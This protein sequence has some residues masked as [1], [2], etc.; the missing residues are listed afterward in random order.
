MGGRERERETGGR[1]RR[2]DEEQT[3]GHTDKKGG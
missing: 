2:G 1:E 3:E